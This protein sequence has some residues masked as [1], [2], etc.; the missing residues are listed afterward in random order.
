MA[1]ALCIELRHQRDTGEPTLPFTKPVDLLNYAMMLRLAA[2]DEEL[3]G[4]ADEMVTWA[5]QLEELAMGGHV[6]ALPQ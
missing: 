6:S 4:A 2:A 5:R 1:T 3:R